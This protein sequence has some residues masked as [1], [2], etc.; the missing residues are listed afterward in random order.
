MKLQMESLVRMDTVSGPSVYGLHP[1][2]SA[3]FSD[4]SLPAN[5]RRGVR[6]GFELAREYS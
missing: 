6:G 3:P 4:V 5:V 1:V 2:D